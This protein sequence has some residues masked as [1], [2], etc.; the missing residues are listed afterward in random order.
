MLQKKEKSLEAPTGKR[1]LLKIENNEDKLIKINEMN[2]ER[3]DDENNSSDRNIRNLKLEDICSPLKKQFAENTMEAL[4]AG[5]NIMEAHEAASL[6]PDPYEYPEAA[7][8]VLRAHY[9]IL[10]HTER[11]IS[12]ST[13]MNVASEILTGANLKRLFFNLLPQRV[14]MTDPKLGVAGTNAEE[15]YL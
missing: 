15:W 12:M 14:R 7:L 9:K 11:F 1:I 5:E 13:N 10:Q 3:G 8:K 6:I 4:E 2:E